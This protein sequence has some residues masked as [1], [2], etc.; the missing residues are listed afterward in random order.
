M[1]FEQPPKIETERQEPSVEQVSFSDQENNISE[2]FKLC[3]ELESIALEGVGIDESLANKIVRL[4]RIENR[5]K[6][7]EKSKEGGNNDKYIGQ[8]FTTDLSYAIDYIE[9]TYNKNESGINYDDT[10][11]HYTELPVKEASKYLVSKETITSEKLEAEPDNFHIEDRSNLQTL[12]LADLLHTF[13]KGGIIRTKFGFDKKHIEP[14]I[15]D[16]ISE[17]VPADG[18]FDDV[19]AFDEKRKEAIEEYGKYLETIFP[20]SK[21][22]EIVYHGTNRKFDKFERRH[23]LDDLSGIEGVDDYYFTDSKELARSFAEKYKKVLY[24]IF[25]SH[26]SGNVDWYFKRQDTAGDFS[27]FQDSTKELWEDIHKEWNYIVTE[28]HK[29][30]ALDDILQDTNIQYFSN[31]EGFGFK[32]GKMLMPYYLM[33]DYDSY[34]EYPNGT[35]IPVILDLKKPYIKEGDRNSMDGILSEAG[36]RHKKE[37]SE[38]DGGIQQDSSEKNIVVFNPEQIHVLGSEFD[39]EKFKEFVSKNESKKDRQSIEGFLKENGIEKVPHIKTNFFFNQHATAEDGQ[40]VADRLKDKD[41]F[42][43]E[44]AGW[45]DE[46]LLTWQKV[47]SGEFTADQAIEHEKARGK[48]F[49]WTEYYKSIFENIHGTNKE[50]LLVDIKDDSELYKEIYDLMKTDGVYWNILDRSK[51]YDEVIEH[52]GDASQLESLSQEERENEIL[53]NTKQNLLELLKN[54]P[55]LQDKEELNV[56]FSMGSFHTRLYHEM[57]KDGNDV[58][59]EHQ[60][61]PYTFSPRME[62]ERLVHFKGREV[63]ESSMPKVLLYLLLGKTGVF[64]LDQMKHEQQ[65][66]VMK[67]FNTDAQI[68]ELYERYQ[69][70]ESDEQFRKKING[71]IAEQYRK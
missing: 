8:W 28:S 62:V 10:V 4:Y 38:I 30:R 19:V 61:M 22:K 71:W 13:K 55:E 6:K 5:N 45:D 46:R 65:H 41:I 56:L 1:K 3:P 52:I 23:G 29:S 24:A 59:R 49:F 51:T 57:K 35:V 17:L 42:I 50:V 14:L 40:M 48:A 9:N 69:K 53:K 36:Y 21:L 31:K 18:T 39:V 12:E 47:T 20:E 68:R 66:I 44:N 25:K 33:N 58:T 11:L 7:V 15:L 60:S 2:V 37:D 67:K 27:E 16:Q 43:Q 63:A 32:F 54:K 26:E 34:K 64:R 70:S